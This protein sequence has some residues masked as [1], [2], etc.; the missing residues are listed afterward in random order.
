[1]DKFAVKTN[2]AITSIEFYQALFDE[3]QIIGKYQQKNVWLFVY[4]VSV[5]APPNQTLPLVQ[6][7]I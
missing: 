6:P 7:G 3:D 1:M 5:P 4:S 2:L